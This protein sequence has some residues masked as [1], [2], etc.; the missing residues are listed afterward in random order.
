MYVLTPGPI[1]VASSSLALAPGLV[2]LGLIAVS[3]GQG[4]NAG[5]LTARGAPPSEQGLEKSLGWV[6]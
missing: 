4:G 2:S 3:G 5:A 6:E 1:P